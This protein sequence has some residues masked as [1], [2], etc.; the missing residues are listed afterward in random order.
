MDDNKISFTIDT[1]DA[2]SE[3]IEKYKI[4]DFDEVMIEKLENGESV[5]VPGFIILETAKKMFTEELIESEA[6]KSLVNIFG[7]TEVDSQNLFND[8]KTKLLPF[9]Q[10]NIEAK[11][12]ENIETAKIETERETGDAL[13]K[14][15]KDA[16]IFP[17]SESELAKPEISITKKKNPI[18]RKP[19]RIIEE[20]NIQPKGPDSYREPIN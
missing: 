18:I 7:I 13:E 5:V 6:L 3:I 20:K 8:I 15:E 14:P 17:K 11:K 2:I 4:K 10:K 12:L 19:Q 16:N 1:S 9:A